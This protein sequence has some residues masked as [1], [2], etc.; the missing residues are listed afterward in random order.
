MTETAFRISRGVLDISSI[1]FVSDYYEP[2]EFHRES[3]GVISRNASG[4]VAVIHA[5]GVRSLFPCTPEEAD[6]LQARFV[7]H[8]EQN[9]GDDGLGSVLFESEA[10]RNRIIQRIKDIYPVRDAKGMTKAMDIMDRLGHSFQPRQMVLD[11]EMNELLRLELST[12]GYTEFPE[13]G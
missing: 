8:V 6:D 12:R 9:N 3:N 5:S 11:N 1:S 7:R 13:E 4:G 10:T 2:D